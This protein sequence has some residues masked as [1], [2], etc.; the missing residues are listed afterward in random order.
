M[1]P[2]MA[3]VRGI[4]A[5]DASLPE[6][7][8]ARLI[9]AAKAG[10]RMAFEQLV[11]RHYRAAFA[12]GLARS[13]NRADAE[14]LVHDAFVRAA[15]R[16]EH[17]RHPE[18]FAAWLCTIVRNLAHNL[19]T[20]G[21]APRTTIIGPDMIASNESPERDAQLAELRDRLQVALGEL[22]VIQREVVLLHDVDGRTHDEI[23]LIVGTSSGMCR[24]H[25]FKARKRLRALLAHADGANP[26]DA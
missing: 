4:R 3:L 11:Q 19:R 23:A 15:E 22:P 12:V 8:D 17:C 25:L 13:G 7:S 14:D 9:G 18:K 2:D 10:D 5:P 20:R 26:L 21:L 6:P 16:L 1:S 24:Q